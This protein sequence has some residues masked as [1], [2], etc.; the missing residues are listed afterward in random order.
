MCHS[1]N[2]DYEGF[3]GNCLLKNEKVMELSDSPL[4]E[5]Y[6]KCTRNSKKEG[7]KKYGQVIVGN[8]YA[9]SL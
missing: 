7:I 4:I 9:V 3:F 6:S 1:G 2:C 5:V 8:E